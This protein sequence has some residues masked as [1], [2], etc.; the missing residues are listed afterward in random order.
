MSNN[1]ILSFQSVE[2]DESEKTPRPKAFIDA[3]VLECVKQ[4]LRGSVRGDGNWH[5]VKLAV[6][7]EVYA[8]EKI[9]N[10]YKIED[11]K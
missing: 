1:N 5:L 7:T 4:A 6:R 2:L 8:R 3:M 9:M 11:D 10:Y